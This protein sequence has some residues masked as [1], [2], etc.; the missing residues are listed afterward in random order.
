MRFVTGHALAMPLGALGELVFVTAAAGHHVGELVNAS[1]VAG[2][3]TRMPQIAA[4]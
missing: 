2:F 1:F 3:T 4:S